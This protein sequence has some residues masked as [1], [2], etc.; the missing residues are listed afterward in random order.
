MVEA[1]R[2]RIYGKGYGED[3]AESDFNK[4]YALVVGSFRDSKNVEALVDQLRSKG[5]NPSTQAE[6]LKIRVLISLHDSKVNA[7]RAKKELKEI[8][9]DTWVLVN[10]CIQ[11]SEEEHQQKRRTDFK[12]I[13]L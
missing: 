2:Q 7:K 10:P 8:G 12:V 11:V 4:D 5:F 9:I 3:I 6:D 13:R 1:I